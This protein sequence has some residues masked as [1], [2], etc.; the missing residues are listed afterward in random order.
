MLRSPSAINKHIQQ[1]PLVQ[2]PYLSPRIIVKQI[3]V[4]C[5]SSIDLEKKYLDVAQEL[6]ELLSANGLAIVFGG[7]D[8]GLMG[9][10]ARAVHAGGGHVTGV[11]PDRLTQID[12]R[13]YA[14]A[15]ELIVTES[16]SERKS[17]IW[18]RSD[19][20]IALAGGIGTLE[21]FLEVITLKKLGYHNKPV[22]LVNTD[23][24][25]NRLLEQFEELDRANFSSYHTR[26][27]FDVV[28]V[29]SEIR[30]LPAFQ[31]FFK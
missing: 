18:R 28:S 12:G 2:V 6:G 25:F 29:P 11:I 14:L 27:L 15:D 13:A 5:A 30:F 10:L 4:Y 22:A 17:I 19:A 23:G 31:E 7:W 21:E 9:V 20:F 1:K 16:M 26:N 24:L 8:V 3:A